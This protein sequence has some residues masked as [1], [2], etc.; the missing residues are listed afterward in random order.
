DCLGD[1]DC[2][3]GWWCASVNQAPNV[4]TTNT[5]YGR[6][7]RPVCLPRW[8]CAP[9]QLDHDCSQTADGRDQYCM[10]DSQ[11]NGYCTPR[12]ATNGNCAGDASCVPHYNVC[13]GGTSGAQQACARDE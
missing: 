4:T 6:P 7:P 13:L 2:P 8:Y 9:C 10:N 12:C 1:S 5:S 11:G 3:S